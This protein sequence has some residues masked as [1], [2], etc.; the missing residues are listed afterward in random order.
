M[1]QILRET[2][3][4]LEDLSGRRSDRKSQEPYMDEGDRELYYEEQ[5]EEDV[6]LDH[7]AKTLDMLGRFTS[8]E[9]T[10]GQIEH[11]LKRCA[12]VRSQGLAGGPEG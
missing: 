3:T 6:C 12:Q 5:E 11:V 8:D 9:A 4:H 7:M 2:N 10:A 1:A